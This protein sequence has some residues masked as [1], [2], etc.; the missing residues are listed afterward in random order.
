MLKFSKITLEKYF[1]KYTLCYNSDFQWHDADWR[2][3]K[4]RN[5]NPW[6]NLFHA[7]P[8]MPYWNLCIVEDGILGRIFSSLLQIFSIRNYHQCNKIFTFWDESATFCARLFYDV[9]RNQAKKADHCLE[10]PRW[11]SLFSELWFFSF[12]LFHTKKLLPIQK[13]NFCLYRENIFQEKI[14]Q[15]FPQILS[16]DTCDG[17]ISSLTLS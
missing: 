6:N 14:M 16:K 8:F 12:Q 10:K 9:V 5:E 13:K 17:L 7:K 11:Q 1:R 3:H 2:K 15:F 4:E